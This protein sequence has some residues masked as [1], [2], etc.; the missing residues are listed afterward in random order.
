[1]RNA[2]VYDPE[3]IKAILAEKHGV[4]PKDVIRNQYSYTV[5]LEKPSE[6]AELVTPDVEKASEML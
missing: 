3:D 2:V 4:Q 5:I 6:Q 1:M